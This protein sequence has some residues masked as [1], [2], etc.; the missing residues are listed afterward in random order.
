MPCGLSIQEVCFQNVALY[1][2]CMDRVPHIRV[3]YILPFCE[4]GRPYRQP[5]PVLCEWDAAR[6]VNGSAYTH[7]LA[8]TQGHYRYVF[9]PTI[10][11]T[12]SRQGYTTFL[13][14]YHLTLPCYA[15]PCLALPCPTC[16]ALRYL[17]IPCFI[18]PSIYIH[19]LSNIFPSTFNMPC[20]TFIALLRISFL[21]LS[22]P[23]LF[24]SYLPA[25]TISSLCVFIFYPD[26]TLFPFF[27][28]QC[29]VF[30]TQ[31]DAGSYVSPIT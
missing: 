17:S 28:K 19:Y 16:L 22:Q 15:L 27:L 20:I 4:W 14:L 25:P 31:S 18:S 24:P 29:F 5:I 12:T 9:L 30:L 8:F 2:S 3:P 1:D 7:L 10:T 13:S 23:F 26:F 6:F 21:I 11:T